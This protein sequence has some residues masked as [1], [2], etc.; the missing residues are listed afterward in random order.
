ML[1]THD[2]VQPAAQA[3]SPA[4]AAPR[5]D[6]YA[7][8]HK[9]LRLY[10]FETLTR[11]GRADAGDI[12]ELSG[13]VAQLQALLSMLRGHVAHENEYVHPPMEARRAGSSRLVGGQHEEHL[14]SIDALDQES[15]E[16]LA[17]PAARRDALTMRLY[18]HL[19]LFVAENLQHMHIEETVHNAEL[20]AAYSDDEL[21]ALHD[22]LIAHI[23]PEEMQQVNHWMAPALSLDELT[24]ML[25]GMK[26]GMPA[27]MF[28][29][30]AAAMFDRMPERRRAQLAQRLGLPPVPG[31]VLRS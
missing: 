18:R 27:P 29:A 22:E 6:F 8:I 26:A 23:A 19:A 10:M 25:Q 24:G 4:D 20:W 9:A 28:E 16:L 17:A 7:P 30:V 13:A 5:M 2:P 21:M 12:D 3:A 31:L 14:A 11:L 1:K 15:L